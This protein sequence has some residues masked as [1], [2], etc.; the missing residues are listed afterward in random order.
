M[1]AVVSIGAATAAFAFEREARAE[2]GCGSVTGSWNVP[3]GGLVMSRSDSVVGKAL[4]P[5]EWKS[6]SMLSV[7][8]GGFHATLDPDSLA[9][10]GWPGYC[11]GG[12]VIADRLSNGWPGVQII[13]QAAINTFYFRSSDPLLEIFY[14]TPYYAADMNRA[15]AAGTWANNWSEWQ[16]LPP[17][18]DA[19]TSPLKQFGRGFSIVRWNGQEQRYLLYQYRD[20]ENRHTGS[21]PG[22]S[23]AVCSTSIAWAFNQA[24]RV[25]LDRVFN[26]EWPANVT[27][28]P[29]WRIEPKLYSQANAI[30]VGNN[31]YNAAVR[32]CDSGTM[33]NEFAGITCLGES[34]CDDFGRQVRNCMLFDKCNTDSDSSWNTFKASSLISGAYTISPSRIGGWDGNFSTNTVD[35][36]PWAGYINSGNVTW[37]GA[38]T[39][40]GCWTDDWL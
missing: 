6:H 38:G 23:G 1:I 29:M 24:S 10:K 15:K 11:S 12:P 30:T 7:G 9:Q 18:Y 40:Y 21:V 4:V 13:T 3:K 16:W 25:N 2:T 17:A 26:S 35:R 33:K 34:V 32:A 20:I 36:G 8:P 14:Q 37:S 31:I 19:N 28:G 5:L 22:R 39:T 27:G